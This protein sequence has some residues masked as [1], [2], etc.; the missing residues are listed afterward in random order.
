MEL[1]AQTKR[2]ITT[3][4]EHLDYRKLG[5]I[6]CDK[7]GDAFWR[8]RR[9]PC[10][11]MGIHIATVLRGRLRSGGR[12]LYVGAGV[13]EIPALV[14]ETLELERTVVPLNLRRE[15]VRVLNEA[16]RDIPLRFR[17]DDAATAK[18]AFDHLWAVS[19]FNDPERFPHLSALSYGRANPV[20]FDPQ[21]F[22]GE[23]RAVVNLVSDCLKK[24]TRPG[25]ITTSVEEVSWIVNWC[26]RRS[27]DCVVEKSVYPTALVG[28]PVC[29]IRVGK[30]A[31]RPKD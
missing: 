31:L 8:D 10:R 11:T 21:K 28:D 12:S 14:M 25:L 2:I 5:T 3:V 18:G 19:V 30:K 9:E 7:G 29:L 15:E 27:V 24:L 26:G 13:A 4:F 22:I 1:K 20:T 16:C 6:Y 23:R 17:S